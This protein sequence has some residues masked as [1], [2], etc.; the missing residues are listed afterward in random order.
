MCKENQYSIFYLNSLPAIF[1]L[2]VFVSLYIEAM[3]KH[4][5]G[6]VYKLMSPETDDIYIGST[7]K[8]LDARLKGH[9]IHYASFIAGKHNHM[10][11]FEIL[12]H[13]N[14]SIE[15]LFEGEFN[16]KKDLYEKE[17][18]Y[19]Q[20][21][22]NAINKHIAGLT[23]QESKNRYKQ[24]NQGII[25]QRNRNYRERNS[26]IIKQRSKAYRE[27][28]RDKIKQRREENKAAI[29]EK[30]KEY[31]ERKK[32]EHMVKIS[33]EICG[34]VYTG[35]HKSRHFKSKKHII[36]EGQTSQE[37]EPEAEVESKHV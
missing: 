2:K 18:Q 23:P 31:R 24:A 35:T 22:V 21:N 7:V 4:F 30:K 10:T 3:S 32:E 33:C 28:N 5:I 19:I 12:K 15:L 27:Q 36:A 37:P 34:G 20:L 11:S 29:N 9:K 1:L 6:R 17:G 8:I 25:K 13:P 26:D 16:F 14:V